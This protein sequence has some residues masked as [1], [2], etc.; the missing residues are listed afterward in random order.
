M[1]SQ[2][3]GVPAALSVVVS[4]APVAAASALVPRRR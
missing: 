4:A 1:P 2:R 3:E